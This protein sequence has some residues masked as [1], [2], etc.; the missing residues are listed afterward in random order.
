MCFV[1]RFPCFVSS[2]F[3]QYNN[4]PFHRVLRAAATVGFA[5]CRFSSTVSRALNPGSKRSCF[6]ARSWSL[7]F[8]ARRNWLIALQLSFTTQNST[9][10]TRRRATKSS[11]GSTS[12]HAVASP[13]SRRGPLRPQPSSRRPQAALLLLLLRSRA[14]AVPSAA[15]RA[16]K[17]RAK[18]RPSRRR[19]RLPPPPQQQRNQRLLADGARSSTTTRDRTRVARQAARRLCRHPTWLS[20]SRCRSN[21]LLPQHRRQHRRRRLRAAVATRADRRRA[22]SDRSR[23]APPLPTTRPSRAAAKTRS[24][25]L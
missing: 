18:S 21:R 23:R 12:L 20:L 11:V 7:C 15:T 13:L 4:S 14:A 19:R 10:P 25:R 2:S 5:S 16:A 6:R 24:R 9:A 17:R 22:R 1:F 3:T 8:E